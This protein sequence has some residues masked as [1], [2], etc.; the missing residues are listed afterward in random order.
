MFRFEQTFVICGTGAKIE[1]KE[2][3]IDVAGGRAYA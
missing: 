1:T 2:I 3:D